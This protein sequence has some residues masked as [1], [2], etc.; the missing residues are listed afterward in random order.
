M[1]LIIDAASF[2]DA[3]TWARKGIDDKPRHPALTG[4]L[5]E[6]VQGTLALS[7]FDYDKSAR[8]T[9]AADVEEPGSVLLPARLLTDILRKLGNRPVTMGV[10]GNRATLT[11]GKTVFTLGTMT[12]GDYPDIPDSPPP[13]GTVDG[14][15]LAAAVAAVFTSASKDDTLP[16]L[17]SIKVSTEG[18]RMTLISTD[19]YRI[20]ERVIDWA[21]AADVDHAFLLK[22]KWLV[23]ATKGTAGDIDLLADTGGTFGIKSGNR[24]ITTNQVD[25]DYPKVGGLFP[26]HT[27]TTVEVGT[28]ELADAAERVGLAAE[29]NTPLRFTITDGTID[30]DAGNGDEATG[31]DSIDC[32]LDGEPLVT[33]FNPMY[34]AEMLRTISTDTVTFGFTTP[35]K[36]CMVTAHGIDGRGLLMPVRLGG[37]S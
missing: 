36:P 15:V 26:D 8:V 6:A 31:R 27:A 25:G 4:V 20:V 22:A 32:R 7:G 13:I 34:V 16:I 9:T 17:T 5:I 3:A 10:E 14:A 37:A 24:S 2:A 12:I 33:A 29:R 30:L 19:R 11:A 18:N 23:D 28:A 21:P 35:A 1:K